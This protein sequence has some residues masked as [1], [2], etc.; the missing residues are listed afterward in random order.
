MLRPPLRPSASSSSS[1]SVSRSPSQAPA[2]IV[3]LFAE[4]TFYVVPAKLEGR[5]VAVYAQIDALGGQRTAR[6]EDADYVLTALHGIPR[7][8]RVL[9]RNLAALNLLRIEFVADTYARCVSPATFPRLP[10]WDE[11][12]IATTRRKRSPSVELLDGP[13]PAKKPKVVAAAE[14]GAAGSGFGDWD[15][16]QPPDV[17]P[18]SAAMPF[19]D[20]PK[21][22]CER[23]CPLTCPNQDI[24]DAIKPIFEEREY[25][26]PDQLN[27][28]VLSYRRSMSN[29]LTSAAPRR[30][31]SGKDARQL[32]GVGDKVASRIDEYLS[33]GAVAES[34][35]ILKSARFKALRTFSTIY[36]IGRPTAADLYDK[37]G[38]RTLADVQAH[39]CHDT[40]ADDE[41]SAK[42][43]RA[44]DLRRI[45]G[46]MTRGEVVMDW[47]GLRDEL[48]AS[49]PRSEVEEIGACVA[50]Q[51]E[52]L[53]PGCEQTICGGYRRGKPRSNDVDVIFRP[54]REG[55]DARLL[56]RLYARLAA[57]GI[58]THVLHV[59]TLDHTTPLHSHPG[60]FDNLDKAFVILRLPPSADNPAPLHR[61][62]DLICAPP[63]RYAA[64]VLSWSGSMMFERDFRRYV[65]ARGLK[66]RAGLINAKTNEEINFGSEREIFAHVGLRYIPPELRNAD[67]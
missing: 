7:L 3:P 17:A 9:G 40:P 1:V 25:D 23:P 34:E 66:F 53:C 50:E 2:S 62:V 46:T 31:T 11:Y 58:V 67:G 64:A 13:S 57:L 47:L 39:Y 8:E 10:K 15:A 55:L 21:L 4:L 5:I 44:R 41:L 14:D 54:P 18:Y 29:T 63:E 59:S 51:L 38:C 56:R 60:N 61:R 16:A 28:N 27:S 6:A 35:A 42:E 43:L 45:S 33:T 49:I 52:A 48:D 37:K 36:T 32:N 65:E 22:A 12:R 19:K 30:F 26:E 20:I 24:I